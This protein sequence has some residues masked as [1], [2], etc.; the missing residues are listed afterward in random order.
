L[1]IVCV[2]GIFVWICTAIVKGGW[3][4]CIGC[5]ATSWPIK[6]WTM[7]YIHWYME[8]WWF[9]SQ[10]KFTGRDS[11]DGGALDSQLKWGKEVTESHKR[12]KLANSFILSTSTHGLM[13]SIVW[14][15]Q[16]NTWMTYYVDVSNL[17]PVK[18]EV[19][20]W[21]CSVVESRLN[22]KNNSRCLVVV[23]WWKWHFT[24]LD[25][26]RNQFGK[27]ISLI[28]HCKPIIPN[29]IDTFANRFF[30]LGYSLHTV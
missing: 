1:R 10:S 2:N 21:C 18:Q 26:T 17:W 12:S 16:K 19:L 15:L 25:I 29:E 23:W 28:R 11:V 5:L 8:N 27:V 30:N 20:I 13:M 3:N 4:G 9:S 6:W 22:Q 7:N 14:H 24:W